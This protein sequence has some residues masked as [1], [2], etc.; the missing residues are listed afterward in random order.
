MLAEIGILSA[1]AVT[2]PSEVRQR[3]VVERKL[4]EGEHG[5]G[6]EGAGRLLA[7]V[8]A[9]TVVELE[10][11][12]GWRGEFDGAA[13]AGDVHDENRYSTPE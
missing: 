1:S 10:R 13:L 8:D 11:C 6:A 9:M 12:R 3:R 2:G 4:E 7:A 5:R